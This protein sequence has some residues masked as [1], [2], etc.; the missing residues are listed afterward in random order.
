MTAAT[1]NL[2][3][4]A[5]A[6]WEVIFAKYAAPGMC[7]PADDQ[8]C[9]SGT[10]SQ[11]QIDNDTRTLAQRQHDAML[12]IGRIALMS[13]E[14]GHLNGLPVAVIIRTTLQD[15]ESRAGIGVT[16]GGTK[17]PIAD[18]IKMGAH[19]HHHLA[20]FDKATGQALALYRAKRVASPAQR[21]ML[22][23]RDGGCTKPCCTVGAYGC[24]VHHAD[25]GLGH[26]AATPTSTR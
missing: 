5:W 2:T 7:N 24:Q 1:A 19:A 18:V 12:A 4:E 26:K 20:V 22:I 23:A 3:P 9:T 21:I 16:G 17:L 11:A 14:L 25:A 13:G 6:V 10:P 15:L 8:P